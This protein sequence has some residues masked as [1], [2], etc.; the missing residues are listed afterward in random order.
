MR[1]KKLVSCKGTIF[2]SEKQN[3]LKTGR[4]KRWDKHLAKRWDKHIAKRW[5]STLPSVGQAP[6]QALDKHL[7]KR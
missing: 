4:C 1:K 2:Y 6:C 3:I 7:V 5:T